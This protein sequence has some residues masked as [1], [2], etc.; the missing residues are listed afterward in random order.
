MEGLR[1]RLREA[2]GQLDSQP[3]GQRQQLLQGVQE[4][5]TAGCPPSGPWGAGYTTEVL[6]CASPQ[7][8]EQLDTAQRAYEDLEFQQ[9]ERESRREEE[10]RD[11]PGARVP[12]AR[13]PELQASVAQHKVGLSTPAPALC[14]LPCLPHPHVPSSPCSL[15]HLGDDPCVCVCV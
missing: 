11:G 13:V 9:L 1:Q 15:E 3:E 7:A 4:V 10:D 14:P 8:R 5:R 12:V 6:R 2:Q